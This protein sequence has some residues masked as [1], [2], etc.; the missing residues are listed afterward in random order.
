[1]SEEKE[2]LQPLSASQM[3]ALEEAIS[4][5]QTQIPP[6]PRS[7]WRLVDSTVT[8]PSRIALG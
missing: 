8:P 2:P 5:Y 6:R 1:V 3:E 4:A 7:T